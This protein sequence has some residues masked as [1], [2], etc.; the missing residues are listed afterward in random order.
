M[1]HQ[2][3]VWARHGKIELSRRELARDDIKDR[4]VEEAQPG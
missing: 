3:N 2:R 1:Q 4:I